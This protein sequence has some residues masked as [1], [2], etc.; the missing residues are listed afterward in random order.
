[1]SNREKTS[2]FKKLFPSRNARQVR[3]MKKIAAKVND[4]EPAMQAL[5][6]EA[7]ADKTQAFKATV[8]EAV[9]AAPEGQADAV[10]Q[11]AL[12]ALLPEAFALVREASVRVLSMRPYDVQLI[13]AMVLHRGSVSEMATGEGKTL[14]STLAI[15]LNA[16]ANKGVHLVTVNPYLASRDA[17]WMGPLY[18]FLG[19]TVS[20]IHADQPFEEKKQAYQADVVYGTNNELGF[21]YLRDNMAPDAELCVQRERFFAVVDEVDSVLI[22][23]ARTP[24]IISGEVEENVAVYQQMNVLLKGLKP[25]LRSVDEQLEPGKLED[26]ED[27]GDFIKDEKTR[28]VHLTEQG[29]QRVE[30]ILSEANLLLDPS[31]NLYDAQNVRLLHYVQAVLRAQHMYKKDIDYMVKDDLILIID[32]HTGRTMSG[33]RWSDGLHQAIEAKEGLSIKSENQTLASI[34]FQNYFRLY[35]KLSGM[36]GTAN[37]EATEFQQIYSLEVMIVPTNKALIRQDDEDYVFMTADE[38]FDAIVKELVHRHEKKQ[39]VLVGTASIESSEHLS[40]LLKKKK[41]P[42]R[43]LN[44]KHHAQEAKIIAQAG[45]L[46]AV[47]I[48][49]NMAG[50]GTDIVLGGDLDAM[51]ADLSNP[52]EKE[53]AALRAQWQKDHEAVKALGGLFVLASERHESRRIDNQLRGRSGRQ[54]D[55]GQSRFYLALEDP[56]VRIFASDRIQVIMQ[57]L[58]PEHGAVLKA[59]MLS[60]SIESAQ[61]K[62]EGHHFDVRKQL[63]RYDDVANEQRQVLYGCRRAILCEQHDLAPHVRD[64]CDEMADMVHDY[65]DDQGGWDL[66]GLQ[67]ALV[68]AF[69]QDFGIASWLAQDAASAEHIEHRLA[70]ALFSAFEARRDIAYPE[71]LRLGVERTIM[72]GVLD[73]LWRDHLLWMDQLRQGIHLRAYAQKNPEHEYKQESFEM[74]AALFVQYNQIVLG[75]L[76]R[77]QLPQEAFDQLAALEQ[78]Q[79]V[80]AIAEGFT[81]PYAVDRVRVNKQRLPEQ[82]VAAPK[83]VGRNDLCP[84]ASGKKFKHCHGKLDVTEPA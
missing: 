58:S 62:V 8:A 11:K 61:R 34:T 70:N 51:I 64:A 78:D 24:L 13:G 26:P 68:H 25:S 45:C 29:H 42:H 30:A 57:N 15:Y 48:A 28:Q 14:M 10:L 63:L 3:A 54:G 37:T 69:G 36:T 50:R 74:F 73:Q 20:V 83:K 38:K 5:S 55:P 17:A 46:S 27:D 71:A 39:P 21:D 47:T 2:L 4:F 19:L 33:R 77:F 23:E 32:E 72:I 16:L 7:F 40:E 66:D 1:M 43:V 84:C 59:P 52:T 35:D 9:S 6:D 31:S 81:K 60:R 49:T 79:D 44:A 82:A 18:R 65:L 22:D 80:S 12:D 56:L 76:L 41:I 67:K 75:Q 53:M